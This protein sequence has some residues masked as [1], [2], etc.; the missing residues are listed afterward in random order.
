VAVCP[1]CNNS[2]SESQFFSHLHFRN[3]FKNES[4]MIFESESESESESVSNVHS[5]PQCSTR[6]LRFARRLIALSTAKVPGAGLDGP[7]ITTLRF[8]VGYIPP[9]ACLAG[10]DGGVALSCEQGW[11]DRAVDAFER[12][13]SGVPANGSSDGADGGGDGGADS[14]SDG[15]GGGNGGADGDGGGG[16]N[17]GVDGGSGDGGGLASSARSLWKPKLVHAAVESEPWVQREML[18]HSYILQATPTFDSCVSLEYRAC[19]STMRSVE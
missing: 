19:C 13:G 3:D 4:E 14:D 1:H 7:G 17:G 11:V 8:V 10:K 9:G 15:D 12:S 2:Q 5:S 18:W 16:G 6:L